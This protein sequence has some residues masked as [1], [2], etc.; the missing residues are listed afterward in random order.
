MLVVKADETGAI[1]AGAVATAGL[2]PDVNYALY[3]IKS[4]LRLAV[5]VP[6]GVMIDEPAL[7]AMSG[8]PAVI[9]VKSAPRTANAVAAILPPVGSVLAKVYAA[10]TSDETLFTGFA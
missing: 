7:L 8:A 6:S 4:K 9:E 10:A 2:L 3:V 5:G 1:P